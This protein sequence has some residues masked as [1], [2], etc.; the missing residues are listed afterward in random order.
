[1]LFF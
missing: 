1:M